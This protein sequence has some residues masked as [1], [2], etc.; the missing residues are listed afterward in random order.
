MR[1]RL[2]R[3]WVLWGVLVG[4]FVW[5]IAST[6]LWQAML[7]AAFPAESRVIY[8]G[9]SL[10]AMVGQHVRLVAISSALTLAISLPLGVWVTRVSGRSF[11]AIT[12][13][14]TSFAQAFPPVAVLALAVPLLGFGVV[15]T[16]VALFLYGLLPVVRNTIAGIEAVP[17]DLLDA[18]YGMGMTAGVAL[19]RVELPLAARVIM[20]GVRT[21][22]IIN[23]GT[24][25]VGAVIGADGLGSPIVAGLVQ[26]NT[27]FVLE[28]A[29]P[30]A[31][32]AVIIDQLMANLEATFFS[33]PA[34]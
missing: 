33:Y 17:H 15:P 1:R 21:S 32:L 5:L 2:A 34:R 6:W 19:F 23:V 10:A 29:I 3:R 9:A 28:G 22:V 18:A 4:V 7:G 12:S 27:A 14:L 16:V 8:P 11:L 30:A 26:D 31:L 25:M 13:D 20:A 24:A